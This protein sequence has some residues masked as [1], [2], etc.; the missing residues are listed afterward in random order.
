MCYCLK[1]SIQFDL[2]GTEIKHSQQMKRRSSQSDDKWTKKKSSGE[3]KFPVPQLSPEEKAPGLN[4]CFSAR[5]KTIVVEMQSIQIMRPLSGSS[6]C[7]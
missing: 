5:V 1:S 3:T 2:N 7:A 4:F 6:K